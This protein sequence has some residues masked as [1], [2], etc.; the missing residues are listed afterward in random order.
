MA[1]LSFAASSSSF[2]SID[3]DIRVLLR[4]RQVSRRWHALIDSNAHRLRQF[5]VES[6]DV[7]ISRPLRL[8]PTLSDRLQTTLTCTNASENRHRHLMHRIRFSDKFGKKYIVQLRLQKHFLSG[9]LL[10]LNVNDQL[11]FS[12]TVRLDAHFIY[13][14][15]DTVSLANHAHDRALFTTTANAR[16][17]ERSPF[18]RLIVPPRALHSSALLDK[19]QWLIKRKSAEVNLSLFIRRELSRLAN[20]RHAMMVT[21][22]IPRRVNSLIGYL[23]SPTKMK[24]R[25]L[26]NERECQYPTVF[27]V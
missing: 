12:S 4:L 21:L 16:S 2:L 8:T 7:Q 22:R 26:I 9:I 10:H 6:L 18:E 1:D 25:T 27:F 5:Q 13:R 20:N 11:T 24:K 17:D 14:F 3:D 23:D 15:L 19:L